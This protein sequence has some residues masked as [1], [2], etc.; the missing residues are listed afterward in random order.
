[1]NIEVT[2]PDGKA[3]DWR[4]E[5]FTVS[6][7]DSDYTR[8]RAVMHPEEFVPAGTYKKLCRNGTIV[9]SNTP[10]EIREHRAFIWHAKG[11]VLIMGLGLGVCLKAILA[12]PEV[13]WVT[14]IEKSPEVIQLVGP[15]FL[16]D[17]RVEIHCADAFTWEPP[18]SERYDA[19]WH[20]IWDN[21]C[22]DNL[23]EMKR[24]KQKYRRRCDWQGCWAEGFIKDNLKRR[25]W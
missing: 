8:M 16:K 5:T 21:M 15:T 18:K 12:K 19:V 2:V 4:V 23:P 22:V 6:K 25:G 1:M 3:G 13:T 17:S 14:V 9:M 11:N 24:L 7:A 10:M 20:D